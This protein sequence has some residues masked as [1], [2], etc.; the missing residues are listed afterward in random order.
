MKKPYKGLSCKKE[1]EEG[2][3][4]IMKNPNVRQITFLNKYHQGCMVSI[5]RAELAHVLVH[6]RMDG[7]NSFREIHFIYKQGMETHI[8]ISE[9]DPNINYIIQ[10]L[11]SFISEM[12]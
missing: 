12:E 9:R 7:E 1:E 6:P 11:F 3:F 4:F 2:K 8:S 5:N 10:G